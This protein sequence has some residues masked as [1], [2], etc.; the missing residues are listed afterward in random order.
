MRV[1]TMVETQGSSSD[2]EHHISG[3]FPR[4]PDHALPGRRQ[5]VVE[6]I[7]Y[8]YA[9]GQLTNVREQGS[10]NSICFGCA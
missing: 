10:W 5:T 2:V 7:C 3:D 1:R 9:Y 6:T 8:E 4:L